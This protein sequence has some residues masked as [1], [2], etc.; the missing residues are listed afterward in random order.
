MKK[1]EQSIKRTQ[2]ILPKSAKWVK[3][4]CEKCDPNNNTLTL[5]DNTTITYDYLIVTP[6]MQIDWMKIPGLKESLEK[7]GS[8]VGSIYNAKY[9]EKMQREISSFDGGRAIFSVPN[10]PVRA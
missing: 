8:G 10:T 2:D 9:A 1:A 5:S 7:D 4:S 6:G 3:G